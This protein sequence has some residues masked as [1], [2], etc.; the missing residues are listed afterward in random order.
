MFIQL[1]GTNWQGWKGELHEMELLENNIEEAGVRL[2]SSSLKLWMSP[3]DTSKD[4]VRLVYKSRVGG[5]K[6]IIRLD[7]EE[8][9]HFKWVTLAQALEEEVNSLFTRNFES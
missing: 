1:T 9:T 7:P 4:T 6:P 5:E 2:D 8:H 3:A